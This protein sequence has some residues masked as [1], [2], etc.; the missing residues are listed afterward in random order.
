MSNKGDAG[1]QRRKCSNGSR[2]FCFPSMISFIHCW[3]MLLRSTQDALFFFF[4]PLAGCLLRTWVTLLPF[5]FFLFSH[6]I[7]CYTSLHLP[8]TSFSSM[9]C[10]LSPFGD[11][12]GTSAHFLLLKRDSD[13]ETPEPVIHFVVPLIL[14]CSCNE[15][16]KESTSYQKEPKHM[17]WSTGGE[18]NAGKTNAGKGKK[19]GRPRNR[20]VH[21]NHAVRH[22]ELDRNW[23]LS[24][25][26]LPRIISITKKACLWERLFYFFIPPLEG[27]IEISFR[28]WGFFLLLV[29]LVL[30]A[31]FFSPLS[32]SLVSSLMSSSN[33][34]H[35][36]CLPWV[37]CER[38][39]VTHVVHSNIRFVSLPLTALIYMWDRTASV[40][41]LP[42]CV[43]GVI[44]V[45][46]LGW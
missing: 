25:S 21:G 9:F 24:L 17:K 13:S 1:S 14:I 43:V 39:R 27:C 7:S 46:E 44:K 40:L 6:L 23:S 45:C 3:A 16:S 37:Y 29:I 2:R 8:L 26:L 33:S 22:H 10:F 41:V 18:R 19:A 32:S 20:K 42:S 30:L 36:C 4:F 35:L 12:K 5:S 38:V 34:S 31:S 28:F 15:W 11:K